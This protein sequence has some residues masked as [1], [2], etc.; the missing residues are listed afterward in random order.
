[1]R[2]IG[3]TGTS[4]S[5]KSEACKI[6][7]KKYDAELIDADKIAKK[8][9]KRGTVY[10]NS[11][12]ESFGSGI[13]N[14]TGEL[15]RKKLANIIYQDEKK[16]EELNKLT[17]LYVVDEIKKII[18]KTKKKIIIVDAPLLFESKLDQ[19]CDFV[20]SIIANEKVKIERICK[21]DGITKKE[22]E[23]RLKAQAPNKFFIENSD[24][25]IY[26]NNGVDELKEQIKIF[27]I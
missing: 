6:L 9:S 14:K 7:V 8:L 18:N 13:V 2:I 1:M 17:F 15:N 5:G 27:G 23:S 16:R 20:I 3:V 25:V 4:G 11:I 24:Y 22:A 10:F 19:I 26:N 21:R 12:V